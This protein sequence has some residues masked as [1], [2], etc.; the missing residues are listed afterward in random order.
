MAS[1]LLIG[2]IGGTNARF[3]LA[4]TKRPGFSKEFVFRCADY[5]SADAAIRQY[6]KEVGAGAPD[7][8]CLAAARRRLAGT[9]AR[10]RTCLCSDGIH[11]TG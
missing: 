4:G 7:V 1:V 5:A 10:G 8:I 9:D 3:A 11:L 2:D 6:L